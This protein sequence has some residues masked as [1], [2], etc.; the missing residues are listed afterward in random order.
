MPHH[1][2]QIDDEE[3]N[4]NLKCLFNSPPLKLKDLKQRLKKEREDKNSKK[5]SE[6][7]KSFK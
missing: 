5:K 1:I 7:K 3:F 6:N 4:K 2:R